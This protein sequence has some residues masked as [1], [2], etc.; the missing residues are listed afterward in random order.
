M[1]SR[2]L[3]TPYSSWIAGGAALLVALLA[4]FFIYNRLGGVLLFTMRSNSPTIASDL[5]L[6]DFDADGD[7]DLYLALHGHELTAP[8]QVWLNQ[9]GKQG[10]V[11]GVF[12]DSGQRL[13]D[14]HSRSAT[15]GDINGD[16]HL[17]VM[18]GGWGV[19]YYTGDGAGNFSGP[20]SLARLL[21]DGAEINP[22]LALG[23]LNGDGLVDAFAG[24][25]CG[26]FVT[27]GGP[28][29]SMTALPISSAIWLNGDGAGNI[30][31][32]LPLPPVMDVALGDADMDGDLDAFIATGDARD[33][34]GRTAGRPNLLWL[35]D[36]NGVFHDSGQQLGASAARAVVVGDVDGDGFLDAIVGHDRGA[37]VWLNDGRGAFTATTQALRGERTRWLFV[38]DLDGDGDLDLFLGDYKSAQLWF[39]DGSG[40]FQTRGR[41]IR[42]ESHQAIALADVTAGGAVEIIVAGVDGY[43][44]WQR[45]ADGTFSPTPLTPID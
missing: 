22:A 38:E 2:K 10:G 45:Q 18:V 41:P 36:G 27:S 24:G 37:Q 35:N 31:Q 42:Y 26:A 17:D 1:A 8:D 4:L 29:A 16:G 32:Q 20:R 39:N 21:P 25:C 5:V 11:A 23:D 13:G 3:A 19:H 30:G 15:P 14:H 40:Q 34:R 33:T 9:G 12:G 7:L 44:V 43:R 6:A 28:L